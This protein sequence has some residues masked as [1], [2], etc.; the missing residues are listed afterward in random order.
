MIK[1]LINKPFELQNPFAEHIIFSFP[2]NIISRFDVAVNDVV[3]EFAKRLRSVRI[4]SQD[5]GLVSYQRALKILLKSGR[6]LH[7]RTISQPL[8]PKNLPKIITFSH[9]QFAFG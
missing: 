7:I 6:A 3:K 4:I 8:K 2:E 5:I 9:I 1:N